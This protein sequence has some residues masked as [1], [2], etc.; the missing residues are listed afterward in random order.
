MLLEGKVVLITGA[1]RGIGRA[2]A[3]ILADEGA[4]VGVADILP[5]V[6]ATADAV[7]AR[8]RRSSAAV[9]D[10]SDPEQVCRGVRKIREELGNF[11]VLVNNAGIVNNIASL[12]TMNFDA[13]QREVAVNLTGAFNMIREVIGPMID[14]RWGR[15]INVSSLGAIGG[16]HRQIGYAA[17]KAGILGLTKTVTL[18]HARNGIT[19]NA[20][21]PGLIETELVSLMPEEIRES[22]LSNIPARRLGRVE[23]AAHLICFLASDKA[24]FINGAEIRIDG[25]MGLNAGSLGSRREIRESVKG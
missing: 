12:T 15:I 17:S 24:G 9:F 8:G 3:L 7:R 14:E 5:E 20:I 16:L 18:E 25:G 11:H 19:C 6:E 10:I 22:A 23:E 4:D 1:A 21:L 13:W 2:T